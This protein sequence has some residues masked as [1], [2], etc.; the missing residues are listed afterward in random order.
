MNRRALVL[1]AAAVAV[2]AF[3]GAAAWY[4]RTPEAPPAPRPA[5]AGNNL[6]RF[7]SPVVGPADA[8]VTIVEFLDPSCEA[9]RAF[10]PFVKKILSDN[11][12]DVKL[13]IR[14]APLHE[15]SDEAVRI[16]EASRLQNKFDD[17]MM[18]LFRDQ[19]QWAL[20]N[21]PDLEK[22]WSIAGGAGLDV[23][24]ARVDAKSEAISKVLAQ[25]IADMQ[26]VNLE[27]T[28]TFYINGKPLAEFGTQQLISQVEAEVKAARAVAPAG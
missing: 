23:A 15:G 18:A 1:G 20:H 24:K 4:P 12:K 6:V 28:P 10:Y 16:L 5:A 21:G 19:D 9:C 11:P 2:V 25:D 27:G 13:V 17:V 22:A 8:P 14:Y 7:H 26:A 3:A